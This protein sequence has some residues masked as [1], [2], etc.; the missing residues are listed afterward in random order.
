M[1]YRKEIDGLRA[2]AVVPVIFFHAGF[3]AFPG[4]YVGVDIFFVISGFLIT[5]IILD[6]KKKDTFTFISF[7]ERRARR[8]W[9]ALFLVL[10]ACLP[11]AWF[12]L[13]ASDMQIFSESLASVLLFVSNILFWRTSGYFN[14]ET[15]LNPL[16]HTWSLSVEEQFYLFFP[17]LLVAG[18]RLG[19]K[20]IVVAIVVIA[21]GSLVI[22]QR[23]VLYNPFAAFYLLPSRAWE[24]A[25]GSLLAFYFAT[26]KAPLPSK[27][28]NQI[29]SAIGFGLVLYSFFY[30]SKS[31]PFPGNYAIIPTVGTALII[32][33]AT[34]NTVVGQIL[35]SRLFVGIGLISYSAYLWH[36]PLFAFAKHSHPT[37]PSNALMAALAVLSIV[38]AYGSWRF[39]EAPFR[40]RHRFSR[41]KIFLF[42]AAST[43]LLLVFAV[44]G[45]ATKGFL[46]RFNQ[47]DYALVQ[48]NANQE[49]QFVYYRFG[50]FRDIKFK[51]ADPRPKVLII[52]DSFSQDL[53]NALF[54]AQPDLHNRIQFSTRFV[55]K[56]CGNLFIDPQILIANIDPKQQA[57][58]KKQWLKDDANLLQTIKEADEVWMA[59]DWQG[60]QAPL[61]EQS[62]SNIQ[63]LTRKKVLVFGTKGVNQFK[64][65]SLLQTNAVDKTKIEK[66]VKTSVLKINKQLQSILASNNFIDLQ[67]YL[68]GGEARTCLLFTP[69]NNL[70]TY[71]GA[72]LTKFGAKFLGEKLI[73]DPNLSHFMLG[74]SL[75]L[76]IENRS[77]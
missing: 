70:I 62:I 30:F 45:I 73:Y 69:E 75:K 57:M 43:A 38:L 17:V 68:C 36:Q 51:G 20:W 49:G 72:H 22:A 33:S 28:L 50:T 7:Y 34:P 41:Q 2:L 40:D 12:W 8:I 24:L 46:F 48:L 29:L 53:L 55:E 77:K 66:V 1:Q 23:G 52:G 65:Q 76:P 64:I 35:S 21:S 42:G 63:L 71:D 59:A 11:F 14:P 25:V 13:L 26:K 18:W 9:P 27:T 54:E 56:Q 31:T 3:S 16:L 60:W 39:V 15:E 10:F 4:G 32:L 58:C 47:Q 5:S 61:I 44:L 19:T 74:R 37:I 67:F 6:E